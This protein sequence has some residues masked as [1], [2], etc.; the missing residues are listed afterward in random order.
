MTGR[1]V[2]QRDYRS[3]ARFRHAL[4]VFQRF[5]EEAARAA[6]VTPS[7]HQLMLAIKGFAGD[8][9]PTVGDLAEALQLRHHST[10]ELIQRAVRN[11]LLTT[12]TDAS[13]NR[14]QLIGLTPKGEEILA[15]L[16]SLH[17]DELRRFRTEMNDILGELDA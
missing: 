12:E 3:L 15:S 9:S 14:R 10:V 4:R 8:G 5:S 13:D 17:R 7:Q 11:G 2:S 6:G 16:S 1:P